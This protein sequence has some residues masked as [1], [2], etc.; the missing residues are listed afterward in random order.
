MTQTT[1]ALTIALARRLIVTQGRTLRRRARLSVP[2]VAVSQGI[3][4]QLITKWEDGDVK[5]RAA[6][7]LAYAELLLDLAAIE[8]PAVPEA[9]E[10]AR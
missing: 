1:D 10:N 8:G 2:E 3:S 7:A 6:N 5:P 9:E 4:A